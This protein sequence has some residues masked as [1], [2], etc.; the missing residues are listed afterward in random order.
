[1]WKYHLSGL[2]GSYR[3]ASGDLTIDSELR[4]VPTIRWDALEWGG[5]LPSTYVADALLDE[6]CCRVATRRCRLI[7]L[8]PWGL[9]PWRRVRAS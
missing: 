2:K 4:L 7:P 6:T 1:V 5:P 8:I 9:P 3:V